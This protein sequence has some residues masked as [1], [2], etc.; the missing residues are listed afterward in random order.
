MIFILAKRFY[1]F[2]MCR[3]IGMMVTGINL[4]LEL[5]KLSNEAYLDFFM[6]GAMTFVSMMSESD[7]FSHYF[8]SLGDSISNT[9][10]FI[11]MIY[12]CGLPIF[13]FSMIQYGFKKGLVDKGEFKERFSVFYEDY[14]QTKLSTLYYGIVLKARRLIFV[15]VLLSFHTQPH[16][17][18][19]VLASVSLWNSAYIK[20][21]KPYPDAYQ[22]N[23]EL[24][25]ES[26]VYFV[27]MF[28]MCFFAAYP[29]G[30]MEADFKDYAQKA[31][32]S[33]MG[34]NLIVNLIF[35]FISMLKDVFYSGLSKY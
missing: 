21:V 22:N 34:G 3:Q 23:I 12:L 30:K 2:K 7:G 11:I 13:E 4:T 6:A 35:M 29:D 24:F 26:A 32:L 17:Q 14:R 31:V 10:C 16:L 8:Q 27:C 18:T 9:I 5:V 19:G 15:F 20:C 25:N 1:R 33:V 28:N